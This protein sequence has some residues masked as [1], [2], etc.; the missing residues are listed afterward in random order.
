[1][2]H[3]YADLACSKCGDLRCSCE[4]ASGEQW[5]N[6]WVVGD[7]FKVIRAS[8]YQRENNQQGLGFMRRMSLQHFAKKS[9]AMDHAKTE[10]EAA[11]TATE[12]QVVTLKLLRTVV[13]KSA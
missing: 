6:Q 2:G 4:T 1:M 9:D 8:D 3:Y 10:L 11:I 12:A 7:G 5:V 13:G